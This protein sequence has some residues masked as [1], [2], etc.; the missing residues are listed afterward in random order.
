M[1]E[2][3][4]DLDIPEVNMTVDAVGLFCPLPIVKLKLGLQKLDSGQILEIVSDDPGF[5]QDLIV[6]CNETGNRLVSM[7]K[8]EDNV[9]VAHVEKR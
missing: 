4:M 6:F 5:E 1:K 3:K 9:F 8:A 2:M 7:E